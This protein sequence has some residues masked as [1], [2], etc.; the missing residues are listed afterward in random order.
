MVYAM[1]LDILIIDV[2]HSKAKVFKAGNLTCSNSKLQNVTLMMLSCS[3]AKLG[4]SKLTAARY[5]DIVEKLQFISIKR[6]RYK[7]LIFQY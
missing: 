5:H 2:N 6:K 1:A 7:V 3:E 4:L